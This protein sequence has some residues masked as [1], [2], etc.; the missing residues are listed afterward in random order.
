M[1]DISTN[2]IIGDIVQVKFP[3]RVVSFSGSTLEVEIRCGNIFDYEIIHVPRFISTLGQFLP[4]QNWHIPVGEFKLADDFCYTGKYYV[5][6]KLY[7]AKQL[8][9]EET[10]AYLESYIDQI[11][12]GAVLLGTVVYIYAEYYIKGQEKLPTDVEFFEDTDEA[13]H[14]FYANEVYAIIQDNGSDVEYPVNIK[15]LKKL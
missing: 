10:D 8:S 9:Q 7:V 4:G 3:I 14:D 6:D 2:I 12:D 1:V 5:D 13:T 15:F 11:L